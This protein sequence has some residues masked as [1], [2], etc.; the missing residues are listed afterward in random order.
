VTLSGRSRQI[1]FEAMWRRR[2]VGIEAVREAAFER[3]PGRAVRLGSVGAL[4]ATRMARGSARSSVVVLEPEGLHVVAQLLLLHK[5]GIALGLDLG[6]ALSVGRL[7][8][9]EDIDEVFALS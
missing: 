2:V 9:F 6:F 5:G 4:R 3:R 7:G 1:L 8:F